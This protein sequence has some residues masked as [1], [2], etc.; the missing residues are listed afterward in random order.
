MRGA[1]P[2]IHALEIDAV[3]VT[4]N[5]REFSYIDHSR[6]EDGLSGYLAASCERVFEGYGQENA[7]TPA[8]RPLN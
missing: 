8:H 7:A 2:Q 1:D 4:H 5:T 6:L 3:L